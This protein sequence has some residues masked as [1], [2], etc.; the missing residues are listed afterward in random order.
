MPNVF[1]AVVKLM[2]DKIRSHEKT[3]SRADYL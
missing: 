2:Q 3:A 1:E